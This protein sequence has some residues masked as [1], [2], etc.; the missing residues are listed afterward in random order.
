MYKKL[1]K[2]AI[3]PIKI[4]IYSLIVDVVGQKDMLSQVNLAS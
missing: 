3:D 2:E 1:F 4:N